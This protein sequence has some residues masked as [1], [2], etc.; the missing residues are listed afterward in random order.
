MI[1]FW[2]YF[3]D[4]VSINEALLVRFR[5]DDTV[6]DKGFSLAFVAVDR[7]DSDENYGGVD[8]SSLWSIT[9]LANS[10]EHRGVVRE[11][12][13]SHERR[14]IDSTYKRVLSSVRR[15]RPEIIGGR[16]R[17]GRLAG[18]SA[19]HDDHNRLRYKRKRMRFAA[20]LE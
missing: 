17:R 20:S 10:L 16:S 1:S 12:G 18:S 5:T 14:R 3:S 8:E 13:R 15:A 11:Y 6:S 4:I 19:S 9:G 2:Q 7:P